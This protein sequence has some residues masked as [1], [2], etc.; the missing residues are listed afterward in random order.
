MRIEKTQFRQ[1]KNC[2]EKQNVLKEER[3][4][5]K[6]N[7]HEGEEEVSGHFS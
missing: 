4:I 7:A 3:I 1:Q 2:I 6:T 5:N